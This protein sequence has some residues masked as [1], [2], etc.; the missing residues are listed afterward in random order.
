MDLTINYF[1]PGWFIFSKENNGE[2]AISER[3]RIGTHIGDAIT[4]VAREFYLES[5][6]RVLKSGEIWHHDYE[7]SSPETF[8]LF[9]QTAYPLH[10]R[11]G[12]VIV[13]SLVTEH[14]HDPGVDLGEKEIERI[15]LQ[16][17]GFITQCSNCR[18]VQRAS[19]E[20]EWDWVPALVSKMP[21]N[22]SHTFCQICYDYY[23][24]R[25]RRTDER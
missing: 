13:N 3:F 9:H 10:S 22:V 16:K 12:I 25:R 20:S 1:N 15:Y 19:S 21:D 4:G 11:E 24:K 5:F 18:R 23:F 6:Q 2:P 8:R 7:C 14:P 17:T